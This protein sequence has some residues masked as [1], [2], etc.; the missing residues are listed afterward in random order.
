MGNCSVPAQRVLSH[1][2]CGDLLCTDALS[3]AAGASM[4]AATARC[5]AAIASTTHPGSCTTR[6]RTVGHAARAG[7]G[8]GA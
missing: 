7:D 3:T 6:N 2:G 1:D 5:H 4:A 8:A